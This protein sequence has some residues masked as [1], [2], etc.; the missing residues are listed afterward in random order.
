MARHASRSDPPCRVSVLHLVREHVVPYVLAW[1]HRAA[2]VPDLT[3][4]AR[5]RADT[6]PHLAA[7]ARGTRA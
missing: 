1:P 5:A 3:R 4:D 2:S 7:S 6:G